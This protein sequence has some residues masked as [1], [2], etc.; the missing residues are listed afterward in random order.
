MCLVCR[1]SFYESIKR[2][3]W[4]VENVAPHS[5][6][7]TVVIGRSMEVHCIRLEKWGGICV[8]GPVDDLAPWYAHV[9]IVVE[10]IFLD[11]G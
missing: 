10:L 3:A 5:P 2:L 6:L 4:F 1:R 8:V 9:K 11:L 7:P